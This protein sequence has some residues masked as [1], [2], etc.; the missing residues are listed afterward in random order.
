ML[1]F[2]TKKY[3]MLV[4]KFWKKTWFFSKT[5]IGNYFLAKMKERWET[6]SFFRER[7]NGRIC[8]FI[9]I[10]VLIAMVSNWIEWL[11]S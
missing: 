3:H 7:L 5:K 4:Y 11:K 6:P 10:I 9:G 8:L 2:K 1:G